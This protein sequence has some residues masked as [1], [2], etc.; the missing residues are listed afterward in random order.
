MGWDLSI[1]EYTKPIYRIALTGKPTAIE[2]TEEEW[3]RAQ[4]LNPHKSWEERRKDHEFGVRV[5]EEDHAVINGH[6][7]PIRGEYWPYKSDRV[8]VSPSGRYAVL[9][10]M[11]GKF[12]ERRGEFYRGRFYYQIYDLQTGKEIFWVDGSWRGAA[13]WSFFSLTDWVTDNMVVLIP[14]PEAQRGV[15]LCN[16]PE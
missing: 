2:A 4:V 1:L 6:K 12:D 3:K 10:S 5:A 7:L 11:N 13:S 9:H 15:L 16:V 8:E 14:D